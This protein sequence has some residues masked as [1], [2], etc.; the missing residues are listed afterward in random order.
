MTKIIQE[1]SRVNGFYI[2]DVE[3]NSQ[4]DARHLVDE[5]YGDCYHEA[6]IS[7]VRELSPGVYRVT[8]EVCRPG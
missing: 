1:V 8:F 3:A 5:K 4:D 6:F 2:V 7:S